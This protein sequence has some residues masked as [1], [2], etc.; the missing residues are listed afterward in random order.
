M[1]HVFFDQSRRPVKTT[2]F[3]YDALYGGAAQDQQLKDRLARSEYF[4]QRY[5]WIMAGRTTRSRQIRRAIVEAEIDGTS[6]GAIAKRFRVT[7]QAV[8]EQ[9]KSVLKLD[10]VFHR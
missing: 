8:Y 9:A 5:E 2:G 10:G 3:D 7:R 4:W 6:L 1:R